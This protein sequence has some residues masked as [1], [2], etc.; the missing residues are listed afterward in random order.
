MGI[1][2]FFQKP[3]VQRVNVARG[4]DW[5]T[6]KLDTIGAEGSTEPVEKFYLF[7]VC[8]YSNFLGLPIHPRL[9]LLHKSL[10]VSAQLT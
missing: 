7:E 6:L 1:F 5:K 2:S 3:E 4:E 10:T 9:L 8:S